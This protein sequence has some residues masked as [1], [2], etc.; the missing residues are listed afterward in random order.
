LT[1]D[2]IVIAATGFWIQVAR[3]LQQRFWPRLHV[4]TAFRSWRGSSRRPWP[5]RSWVKIRICQEIWSEPAVVAK[6]RSRTRL[7][8]LYGDAV[9]LLS[10]RLFTTAYRIACG[11][12]AG[13]SCR[14]RIARSGSWAWLALNDGSFFLCEARPPRRG[15]ESLEPTQMNPVS[16]EQLGRARLIRA[17]LL[18]PRRLAKLHPRVVTLVFHKRSFFNLVSPKRCFNPASVT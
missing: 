14:F 2:C 5:A 7:S 8:R 1:G 9:L 3:C 6:Q 16:N 17:R 12:L 10:P 13:R 15:S 11:T 4:Y 18:K